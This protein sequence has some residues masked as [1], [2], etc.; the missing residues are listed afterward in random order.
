MEAGVFEAEDVARLH[1]GDRGFR[2]C[3]DA[4]LRKGDRALD[5]LRDGGCDR[6][7]GL[8]GVAP[9][10]A[11]EVRQENH[12]AALVGDL[13]DGWRLPFDAGEVGDPAVVSRYVEIDAQKDA[14]AADVN[15][16]ECS[17]YAH[18]LFARG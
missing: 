13:G 9:L 10:R 2:R 7:Q 15:A 8:L 4:I 16:V 18:D 14:L 1:R 17:K 12:L 5:H 6:P 3:A 11:A